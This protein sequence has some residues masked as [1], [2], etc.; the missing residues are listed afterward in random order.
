VS[1]QRNVW[2]A[3]LLF[4][5]ITNL[6]EARSSSSTSSAP[7]ASPAGTA[8]SHL[9]LMSELSD[10]DPARQSDLMYE[11][12]KSYTQAPTTVNTLRYSIALAVPGHPASNPQQAKKLLEQ[13]LATPER[14][15]SAERSVAQ[16]ML[17]V[18]D[19]WLK[20]Q[21]DNRR[22]AATV[23]DKVRAQAN[24]DRRLQVQ[25]E[26]IARLR[27]ALDA[28]QQKLDAIKDIERSSSE[29]SP[30]SPGTRDPSN[31]DT[32]SQTQAA[33]AGR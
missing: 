14:M 28:A 8:D 20:M 6:S 32:P 17:N 18:A 5:S 4:A 10:S 12:E 33:P 21:A 22:L 9:T 25:A 11:V 15:T 23:D 31:R 27:R 2:I 16:T 26:E 30:S 29:R 13:L 24:S 19:Q 3:L 1:I 7:A